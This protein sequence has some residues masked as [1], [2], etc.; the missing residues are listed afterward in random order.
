MDIH[1]MGMNMMT[2]HNDLLV[3]QMVLTGIGIYNLDKDWQASVFYS[4]Y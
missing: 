1:T 4:Q 2:I 3:Q